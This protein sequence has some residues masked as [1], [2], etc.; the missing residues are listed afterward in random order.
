LHVV[1]VKLIRGRRGN[2]NFVVEQAVST[3]LEYAP[4]QPVRR[5]RRLRR[6]IYALIVL[7]AGIALWRA[8]PPF[9]R[10]VRYV[11]WQSRCMSFTAPADFVAYEEAPSRAAAL[12]ALPGHRRVTMPVGPVAIWPV[13]FVPPPLARLQVRWTSMAFVHGRTTPA[14]RN[15]LVVL[16]YQLQANAE[17]A[18][19]RA[20]SAGRVIE[21]YGSGKTTA[22]LI[23]GSEL[24]GLAHHKLC[25]VLSGQDVLRLFWGQPDSDHADHFT[26]GYRLNDQPGTIDG[27]LKDDGQLELKVRDGPAKKIAA[28]LPY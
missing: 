8:G 5:R 7:S 14:G 17:L 28:R 23:P 24:D 6:A 26:I 16:G 3:P 9:V 4:A 25:L 18:R 21:L 10:Q 20:G 19:H 12:L 27:W 22:T 15:R 13:G 1:C 11:Y 2:L